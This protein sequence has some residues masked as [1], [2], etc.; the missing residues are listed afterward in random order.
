LALGGN[1]REPLIDFGDLMT[2]LQRLPERE[3]IILVALIKGHGRT[4]K[5]NV[6]KIER[7]VAQAAIAVAR[8]QGR[9]GRIPAQKLN[10][11]PRM[12]RDFSPMH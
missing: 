2:G 6:A 8:D 5:G 4:E 12:Q 7:M 3:K 10:V 1:A 11:A 9:C